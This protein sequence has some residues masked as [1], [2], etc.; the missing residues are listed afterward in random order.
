MEVAECRKHDVVSTPDNATP[1][2]AAVLFAR[3][4]VGT[5][6]VIDRMGRLVGILHMRDLLTL[7]MPA[8]TE[9]IEDIDF[10]GDFGAV[11]EQRP[12]P[13][14]LRKLVTEV[15]EPPT[16]VRATSGLLRAFALMNHHKLYDLPIVDDEDRL[17]GLASR[18]DVGSALLASW[19]LTPPGA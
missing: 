5:L 15:I 12:E 10:V 14:V 7:V 8:F 1:G 18:V 16:A 2:E 13:D 17:V 19:R 9:L 3:K 6:P 11:E 4:H